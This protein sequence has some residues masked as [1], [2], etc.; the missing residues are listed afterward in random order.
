MSEMCT[1]AC[2]PAEPKLTRIMAIYDQ[3]QTLGREVIELLKVVNS[4]R[5][6]YYAIEA[7]DCEEEKRP[8]GIINNIE[9][10]IGDIKR[11]VLDIREYVEIL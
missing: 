3:L 5:V 1:M 11:M 9:W 4:K 6:E 7:K 8:G 10:M 2:E